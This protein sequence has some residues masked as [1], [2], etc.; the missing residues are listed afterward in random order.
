MIT[1]IYFK[2]NITK[3]ICLNVLQIRFFIN[4]STENLMKRKET[5]RRLFYAF[6]ILRSINGIILK[7]ISNTQASLSTE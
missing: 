4:S 1:I 2:H 3:I 6:S 5:L 7:L